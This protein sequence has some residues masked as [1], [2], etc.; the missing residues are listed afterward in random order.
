MRKAAAA[1]ALLVPALLAQTPSVTLTLEQKEAFLLN[2]TV[3]RVHPAK[4]G[5]TGTLRATL[6]DGTFT[7]DASIQKIDLQS[8][9]FQTNRGVE[10]HFRDCYKFNIAAWRLAQLLGIAHMVPPSVARRYGGTEASFTWWIDDVQMDETE[11]M[12]RKVQAPDKNLWS[13]E[14]LIMKVFDQLIYNTDRNAQNIL[15]D[16]DWHIWMIDHSRAFRIQDTL[17]EPKALERCDLRLLNAMKRLEEPELVRELTPWLR[18]TEIKALLTRRDRI[19]ALFERR[20]DKLYEYLAA[21]APT[22]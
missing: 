20:P 22:H 21:P 6:S 13:R 17:L 15:Y 11:R 7:H 10:M 19:V 3:T 4:K 16:K 2:A 18:I 1:L 14:Y 12:K 8:T 9:R 5:I